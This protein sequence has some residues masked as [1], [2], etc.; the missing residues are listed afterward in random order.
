MLKKICISSISV[1]ALFAE[2]NF[3]SLYLSD[4]HYQQNKQF[5]NLAQ[6]KQI[7]DSVYDAISRLTSQ[8]K[9][10]VIPLKNA[11]FVAVYPASK[12]DVLRVASELSRLGY[13][14][15]IL[16][17]DEFG[18]V[19]LILPFAQIEK[20]RAVTRELI[21]R[22]FNARAFINNQR[23]FTYERY[24]NNCSACQNTAKQSAKKPV[25]KK[26]TTKKSQTKSTQQVA[27]IEA[28]PPECD[29]VEK[30]RDKTFF[31]PKT[32]V[33]V[34]DGVEYAELPKEFIHCDATF[35]DVA[36]S[37]GVDVKFT[38]DDNKTING[39]LELPKE[40]I[41]DDEFFWKPEETIVKEIRKQEVKK[42][43]CDFKLPYG[44]R[45]AV[46]ENNQIT[47]LPQTYINK[48]VELFYEILENYVKLSNSGFATI[49]I[50]KNNFDNNCKK[51]EQ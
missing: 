9:S 30:M 13:R 6:S 24:F 29:I 48:D 19:V 15:Y 8:N 21:D 47:K 41:L 10:G 3:D 31:N 27:K 32:N 17:K 7:S 5:K 26:K 40:G 42:V 44:I 36:L 43:V 14:H 39:V 25:A 45:T 50:S 23:K 37:N 35:T 46:D 2:P 38:T 33:F 18:K 11:N 49:Y 16:G 51:V 4:F 34:I 28:L 1:C 20:T 22:G 12:S